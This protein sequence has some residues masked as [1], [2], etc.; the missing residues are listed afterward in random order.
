MI[1]KTQFS[2]IPS[3][4]IC[5]IL[6]FFVLVYVHKIDF[7]ALNSDQ[8][9]WIPL[10]ADL[11]NGNLNL[12]DLYSPHSI[13]RAPAYICI[14]LINSYFFDLN[15]QLE[16]YLGGLSWVFLAITIIFCVNKYL[17]IK[18]SDSH[19][20]FLIISIFIPLII[21]NSQILPT[22]L[23]YSVISLRMIDNCLFIFGFILINSILY[24]T[25]SAK[26]ILLIFFY[27]C[28][29]I[30]FFGR[31]WSQIFILSA[32]FG[33]ILQLI[34]TSRFKELLRFSKINQINLALISLSLIYNFAFSGVGKSVNL[35]INNIIDIT[36]FYDF[37]SIFLGRIFTIQF[38]D[39][40]DKTDFILIKLIGSG[41][42]FL[43]FFAV[44]IFIKNKDFKLS[45]IPIFLIMYSLI[46]LCFIYIGRTSNL[47]YAWQGAL[48]PRHLP[49]QSIGLAAVFT[50]IFSSI[51]NRSFFI[52]SSLLFLVPFLLIFI[53]SM[54]LNFKNTV[55][56]N[57][58]SDMRIKS[59]FN[60][61]DNFS[62][63]DDV[64][65]ARCIHQDICNNSRKI[66][67]ETD[68]MNEAR[69]RASIQK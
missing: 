61:K 10:I 65:K 28:F 15:M 24:N 4:I 48:F 25:S 17:K 26:K 37:S 52:F 66:I 20:K 19:S 1:N 38:L 57:K 60:N 3:F 69:K 13:H 55:F 63:Q 22:V 53:F 44:F 33:I 46:A 39:I 62:S 5:L 43:Y 42:I 6:V 27:L 23:G 58:H 67:Y 41:I 30:L 45:F 21:I 36:R 14:F 59:F 9:R 50:I 35:N 47:D 31:G 18:C 7:L 56:I 40:N 12:S 54:S 16:Q 49:E 2:L 68:V 32:I 11:Y 34:L 64:K 51:K 29:A 8:F